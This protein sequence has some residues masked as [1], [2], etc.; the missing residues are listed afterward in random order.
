MSAMASQITSLTIGYSTVY[1]GATSKLRTI[2]LCARNSPVT[3]NVFMFRINDVTM[4]LQ[5][6]GM[7]TFGIIKLLY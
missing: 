5:S 6:F 7:Y 2:G 4:Q 1:S 3:G